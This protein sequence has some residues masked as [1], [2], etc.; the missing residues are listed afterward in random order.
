MRKSADFQKANRKR[1]LKSPIPILGNGTAIF[2][3]KM[4]LHPNSLANEFRGTCTQQ[5]NMFFLQS[6]E[7][8]KSAV[9]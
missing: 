3:V 6:Y 7:V 5:M 4:I 2:G 8:H 1:M 9:M